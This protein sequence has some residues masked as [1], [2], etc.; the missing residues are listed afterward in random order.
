MSAW[1]AASASVSPSATRQAPMLTVTGSDTP[2]A[3]ATV[4]ARIAALILPETEVS[5]GRPA[6]VSSTMNSSPPQRAQTS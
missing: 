3:S 5:A 2:S 1:L 6:S 4:C